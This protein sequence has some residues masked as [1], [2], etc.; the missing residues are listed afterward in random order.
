MVSDLQKALKR[1]VCPF[2]FIA[3]STISATH[4]H[5]DQPSVSS[6]ERHAAGLKLVLHVPLFLARFSRADGI[7][8]GRI[9]LRCGL[10]SSA[11]GEGAT[12]AAALLPHS[13][14]A[15]ASN[16]PES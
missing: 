13:L 7:P 4:T 1:F 8:V 14:C 10:L 12:R 3:A 6:K 5:T 11:T 15:C 9:V 2:D 16:G